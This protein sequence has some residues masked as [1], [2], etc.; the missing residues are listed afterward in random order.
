[1]TIWKEFSRV[2]QPPFPLFI[3]HSIV[4]KHVN[5]QQIDFN[6]EKSSVITHLHSWNACVWFSCL[7]PLFLSY[8]CAYSV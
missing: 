6:A 5:L 3:P 2:L 8:A 1:M 4:L 7:L